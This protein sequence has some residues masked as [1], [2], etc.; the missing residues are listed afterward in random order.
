MIVMPSNATGAPMRAMVER[1]P[2]AQLQH[3]MAPDPKH[4]ASGWMTPWLGAYAIDNGAWGAH[5]N[6]MTW[7][8][9]LFLKLCDRAAL[10]D[11]PPRWVAAP[12][13]VMDW[14]A[15]LRAWER[16]APFLRRT[17]GWPVAI[18]VQNGAQEMVD[19]VKGLGAD[20]VFVGGDNGFKWGSFRRWCGFFPRVHVAR[21]NRVEWAQ[22][23]ARAGVESIDGTGW[24]KTTRQRAGLVR[25]LDWLEH[26]EMGEL[27]IDAA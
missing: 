4:G 10:C 27:A 22:D 25:L 6:R 11:I 24:M 19:V 18:C 8:E 17:Y 16:W 15:T 23:C 21:C 3:L 7:S 9:P 2:R 12:D 26:R 20:L 1:F 14:P 5:K 13:V